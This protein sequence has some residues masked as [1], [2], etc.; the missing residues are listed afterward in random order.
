MTRKI[1]DYKTGNRDNHQADVALFQILSF[2]FLLLIQTKIYY[3][4]KSIIG[5]IVGGIIIFLWQ[6]LSWG[7]LNLHEAQQ[8][9]TPKQDSIL[10]YLGTQFNDDGSLYAA[11]LCTGHVK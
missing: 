8:K 4:R 5:A 3:M 9:Y 1:I 6:L 7:V 11:N 10:A 2:F